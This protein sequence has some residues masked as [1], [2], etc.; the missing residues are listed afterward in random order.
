MRVSVATNDDV[1]TGIPAPDQASR[2]ERQKQRIV[3]AATI[4]LNRKGMRGMTLAEVAGELGLTTTSVTYYFRRKDQLLAAIFDDALARLEVMVHSA[5]A[6]PTPRACVERYIALY[7]DEFAQA[8]REGGRPIANLSEMR[9]MDEEA[10]GRL[11]ARYRAVMREVRGFFGP[12]RDEAHKRLLTARAH[13]LN[14]ALFWQYTWLGQFAIGDLPNVRRRFFHILDGGITTPGTPWDVRVV[15]PDPVT[16]PGEQESF[17]RVA[18]RLINDTGYR[19]ASVKRIMAELNR[20]KGSFY[21]HL[22]AK[23][24]LIVSC[25]RISRR[26]LADLR[27]KAYREHDSPW[28]RISTTVTSA[29]AL[30]LANEF[31]LLR[32]TAYQ[33]MPPA[34]RDLAFLQ[35][36]RFAL[37]V[38]GALVEAMGEGTVRPVDP[39]IAAHLLLASINAAHDLQGAGDGQSIDEAIATYEAVLGDG[40]F[41]PE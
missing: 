33:A 8:Q 25:W 18:I 22:D 26:R 3:D 37:A 24:D 16:E 31:P 27:A 12:P 28:R 32:V 39:L 6:E 1:E 15:E 11:V 34:V 23:D 17:L 14:E 2:Y 38:M 20:T 5:A 19:G 13:I 36:E 40:L 41:D 10:R 9:S 7:F 21:H 30:Q 4:L 35:A 29:L